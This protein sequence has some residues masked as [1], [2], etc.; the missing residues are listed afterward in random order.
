MP[1]LAQSTHTEHRMSSH[2]LGTGIKNRGTQKG[3]RIVHIHI[4]VEIQGKEKSTGKIKI[5]VSKM[6]QSRNPVRHWLQAG[7]QSDLSFP[8]QSRVMLVGSSVAH[9]DT[10]C[11]VSP[12]H[13]PPLQYGPL[14]SARALAQC[15]QLIPYTQVLISNPNL[16]SGSTGPAYPAP[17]GAGQ[18][19]LPPHLSQQGIYFTF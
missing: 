9:L 8:T 12:S 17:Y 4:L 19:S 1:S 18:L 15:H 3:N 14:A 5:Q 2:V 6:P 10:F 11:L 13:L 7:S 16:V